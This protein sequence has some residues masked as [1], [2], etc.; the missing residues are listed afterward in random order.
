MTQIKA[1]INGKMRPTAYILRPK[2]PF[3]NWS[4]Q[5]Y[6][7]SEAFQRLQDEVCPECGNAMWLCRSGNNNL[8]FKVM[9]DVCRSEAAKNSKA[10]GK[11]KL[12]PGEFKYTVPK[13]RFDQPLPSRED[14]F[15]E[16]E[17][18]AKLHAKKQ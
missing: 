13:M 6:D 3:G 8:E 4:K 16:L 9:T 12:K 15:K 2:N 11:R 5:D 18:E 10:E 1:A 7:F 14:Y 17:A